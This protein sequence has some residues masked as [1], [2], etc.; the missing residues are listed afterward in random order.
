MYGSLRMT[1]LTH[2]IKMNQEHDMLK[3]MLCVE[4]IEL[5]VQL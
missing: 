1:K 2:K 5:N 3:K 4:F